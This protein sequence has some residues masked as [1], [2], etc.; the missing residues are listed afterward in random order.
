[1]SSA[2]SGASPRAG[3]ASMPTPTHPRR[4]TPHGH[5][6]SP[7][8]VGARGSFRRPHQGAGRARRGAR[9][10]A[11]LGIARR[12]AQR[13]TRHRQDHLVGGVRTVGGVDG[14]RD[15]RLRAMRR[16]RSTAPAVPQ[17]AGRLRRTRTGRP[18]G[19]AR[20]A[21]RWRARADLPA[22]RDAS[23][24]R[25]GPDGVRRRHRTIPRVRGRDRSPPSHRDAAASRADVRRPPVG[26]ADRV[27]DV[28]SPHARAGRRA[29]AHRRQQPR[30][31]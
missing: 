3:T 12:G 7:E 9:A 21:V 31:G 17:R 13:R 20:R 26:R 25:S 15:R 11:R 18:P 10:G 16:D 2:S 23:R 30:I 5:G 19:R 8:R 29:G 28:A 1:M 22:A 24:D 27:V 4:S 6:P 14:R